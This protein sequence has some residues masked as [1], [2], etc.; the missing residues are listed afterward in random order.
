M[1]E[2]EASLPE[3]WWESY[4]DYAAISNL[5]MQR[6]NNQDS[7]IEIP[8]AGSRI[9]SD[10]GH[11]FMV[12]DGMGAHAAGEKASELAVTVTSQS[13]IKRTKSSPADA[14]KDAIQE[15]HL[16]IRKQGEEEP[17]FHSMG[18]TADVLLLLPEGALNAH[19]GDS[20]TYR[21]RDGIYEQLTFDHSLLWELTRAGKLNT[22]EIPASI[23][24]NIITRSLGPGSNPKVDL[25]GPFPLKK[26]DVF[27]LC[28]DGL[29]GQVSDSE[30]AQILSLYPPKQAARTLVNL[31]NLS[32]GP[33]NVTLIIVK[34][35]DIPDPEKT[36]VPDPVKK[37]TPIPPAAWGTLAGAIGFLLAFFL[38]LPVA[39]TGWLFLLPVAA[40]CIFA[41]FLSLARNTFFPPKPVRGF[42]KPFGKG[43]YTK[44]ASA[45]TPDFAEK[46]LGYCRKLDAALRERAP[47]V[48]RSKNNALFQRAD[49]ACKQKNYKESI[50]CSIDNINE[51]F[52]E[53]MGNQIAQ[54][55]P[56][57]NEK[58][59]ER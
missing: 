58:G 23:P 33:D 48:D 8:A 47:G 14:V 15:A 30:A 18:T 36:A 50:L 55:D 9:W 21:F 54:M 37:R 38:F 29:S 12:A 6:T 11:F 10:R 31:T 45:Y 40:L 39:K 42:D 25:E 3:N 56:Q 53:L 2:N 24:K 52:E 49:A 4:I 19:V 27:L 26:G 1:A 20:R 57:K 16:Q 28:S 44:T 35:L 34:I 7:H 46:L 51:G 5:G 41:V 32:G 59:T 17:S 13:Y 22:K 43:P